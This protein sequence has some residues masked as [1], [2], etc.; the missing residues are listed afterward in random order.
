MRTERPTQKAPE[1]APKAP[2]ER[3]KQLR[4]AAASDPVLREQ[5]MREV[6]EHPYLDTEGA[7]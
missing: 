6:E 7:D 1:P 2:T 5:S 3:E 4:D